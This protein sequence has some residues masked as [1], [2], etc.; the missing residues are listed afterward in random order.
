M[1]ENGDQIGEP[2][3]RRLN[4][5]PIGR[6][7]NANSIKEVNGNLNKRKVSSLSLVLTRA[8]PL[9][10]APPLR[11]FYGLPIRLASTSPLRWREQVSNKLP[12]A[13][14][15]LGQASCPIGQL[16]QANKRRPSARAQ[17]PAGQTISSVILER[18]E[19]RGQPQARSARRRSTVDTRPSS[20][21]LGL[22]GAQVAIKSAR[23][24]ADF[25]SHFPG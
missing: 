11:P 10:L 1:P 21:K 7:R 5:S 16:G 2:T 23:I 14:A 13:R 24:G 3:S 4:E 17:S 9:I 20:R 15:E 19:A 6:A 12:R 18:P 25:L 8:Y 22:M